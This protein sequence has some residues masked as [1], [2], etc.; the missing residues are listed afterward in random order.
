[1]CSRRFLQYG[2][3]GDGTR[4]GRLL[5]ARVLLPQGTVVADISGDW[6]SLFL[7]AL[8]N[9][10]SARHRGGGHIR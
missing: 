9:G 1:M 8:S 7:T 10:S 4:T 3:L 6:H 2:Q 5:P